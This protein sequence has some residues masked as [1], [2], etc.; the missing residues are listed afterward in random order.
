MAIIAAFTVPKSGKAFLIIIG[1]LI[2]VSIALYVKNEQG[3]EVAGQR[4][5]PHEIQFDDLKLEPND[6]NNN[7]FYLT[8]RIKNTSQQHPLHELRLKITLRDCIKPGDC[9]I[10]G[11]TMAWS[12]IDVLPSESCEFED[13][14]YFTN[15][16]KPK[17]E[18]VWEYSVFETK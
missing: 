18:Y 16:A 8:G 11:Q 14:V 6:Y 5:S 12:F 1:I 3:A 4:I 15:L 9:E 17:G 10:V 2:A 7:F 13:S